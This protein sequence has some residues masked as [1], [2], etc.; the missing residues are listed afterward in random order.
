MKKILFLQISFVFFILCSCSLILST[1]FYINQDT[2]QELPN[3][4]A[5]KLKNRLHVQE[6][7]HAKSLGF[8]TDCI[9]FLTWEGQT[10]KDETR[11]YVLRFWDNGRMVIKGSINSMPNNYNVNYISGNDVGYYTINKN[12]LKIEY[13][14]YSAA[15]RTY[16]YKTYKMTRDGLK[17]IAGECS[18]SEEEKSY[19]KYC[20]G[21]LLSKPYW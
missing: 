3:N 5:W 11:Y 4:P 9:Y 16:L 2:A 7:N 19:K 21:P 15:I 1:P 13:F 12:I 17:C 10:W 20:V 18:R 14:S 6:L 8:D